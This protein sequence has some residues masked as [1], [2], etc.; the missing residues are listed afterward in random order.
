MV[1]GHFLANVLPAAPFLNNTPPFLDFK[2]FFSQTS[3]AVPSL[4]QFPFLVRLPKVHRS[5]VVK[6][7][8]IE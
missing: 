2:R 1:K 8:Y 3:I 5:Y 6:Q 4:P 7:I